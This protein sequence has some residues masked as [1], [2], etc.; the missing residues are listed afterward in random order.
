MVGE[1][2]WDILNHTLRARK[3]ALCTKMLMKFTAGLRR[4]VV[5]FINIFLH[6]LFVNILLPK[7][8]KPK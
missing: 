6:A 3:F 8:M 7:N 2:E 4:L 5:N 1:T